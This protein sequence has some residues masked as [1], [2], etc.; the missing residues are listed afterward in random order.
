MLFTGLGRRFASEI[1]APHWRASFLGRGSK[2]RWYQLRRGLGWLYENKLVIRH[3]R[4]IR[5]LIAAALA[6]LEVETGTAIAANFD[7]ALLGRWRT[8]VAELRSDG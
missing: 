1:S 2:L 3:E 7:P 6:Q 4:A 5:T 8:T